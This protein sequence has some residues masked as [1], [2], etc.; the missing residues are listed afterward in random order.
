[1]S[2]VASASIHVSAP[3]ATCFRRFVDF[4]SWRAWM[5]ASFRPLRGPSGA[6]AV[7][8]RLRLRIGTGPLPLLASATVVRV[9]Q[10]RE[11]TWRGGVPGILVGE[12]S[13]YFEEGDAGGTRI[14]SEET[15][16]GALASVDLVSRRVKVMAE[17]IGREQLEGFARHVTPA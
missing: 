9:E 7:G 17:R 15:W 1:M 10:G 16:T 11:I 3:P 13:F 4:P 8:D 5:P 2:F 12:H 6:L 14:R